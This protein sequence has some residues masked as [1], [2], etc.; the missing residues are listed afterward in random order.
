MPIADESIDMIISNAF[1]SLLDL[2]YDMS[3]CDRGL[4]RDEMARSYACFDR[5][6]FDVE[7]TFAWAVSLCSI[8]NSRGSIVKS[9]W[10]LLMYESV[11]D[12]PPQDEDEFP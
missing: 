4:K 12:A 3:T 6:F 9:E 10:G 7:E 11:P 5:V 2:V 1:L 8:L